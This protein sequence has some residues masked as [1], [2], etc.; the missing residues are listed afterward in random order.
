MASK[1]YECESEEDDSSEYDANAD[2][3]FST[4][5]ECACR[6]WSGR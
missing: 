3:C 5:G 6:H 2:S 4:S 1:G